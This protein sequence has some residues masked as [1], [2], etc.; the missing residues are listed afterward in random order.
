VPLS[1][2]IKPN[3]GYGR[4]PMMIA[5]VSRAMAGLWWIHSIIT[6]IRSISLERL[7]KSPGRRTPEAQSNSLGEFDKHHSYWYTLVIAA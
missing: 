1:V 7:Y 6:I 2:A 3:N 5:L 4:L